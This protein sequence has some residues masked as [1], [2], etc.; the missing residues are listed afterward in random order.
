MYLIFKDFQTNVKSLLHKHKTPPLSYPILVQNQ[1]LNFSYVI[2][3]TNFSVWEIG[4]L[5]A[6]L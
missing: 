4:S 1:T 2:H 5:E 3:V 6:A